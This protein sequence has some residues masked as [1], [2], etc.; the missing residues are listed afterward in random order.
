M[1]G[2]V[3]RERERVL[4]ELQMK[5]KKTR[6]L[7]IGAGL[8]GLSTAYHLEER[9]IKD[10]MLLEKNY[11]IGGLCSSI[12]GNKDYIIDYTGHLLHFQNSY[13]EKLVKKLMPGN[14]NKIKRNSF[15]RAFDRDI[16][17]PFQSNLSY[18]PGNIRNECLIEYLKIH[19]SELERTNI[20]QGEFLGYDNFEDWIN[21]NFGKGIA[22]YFMI[23]YNTKLWTVPPREMST[24]WMNN[25]VPKPEIMHVVR[26]ALLEESKEEGYNAYF[27]YPKTGGIGSL[28]EAFSNKLPLIRSLT[29]VSKIMP[30]EKKVVIENL[31]G[32]REEISYEVLI[33]TMP[34]KEL[35]S[36]RIEETPKEIKDY[37]NKL[38]HNSVYSLV[39]AKKKGIFNKH[40]VYYPESVYN[41][42]R[43]GYFNNFSDSMCPKN[44]ELIYTEYAH[45]GKESQAGMRKK[46]FEDL[47][48]INNSDNFRE[49]FQFDIPCAYVIYDKNREKSVEGIMQYLNS[50]NI[51]SIGRYGAW[52]YS[53]MEDAILGGKEICERIVK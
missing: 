19:T 6:Y 26:G 30:N 39:I 37:G 42:Y 12:G 53:A 22:K 7:I 51:Y 48:Q 45:R 9:G 20:N 16:P 21:R 25:Y 4:V 11:D 3:N 1:E 44:E 5:N 41:T 50:K 27:Y 38:K 23:P 36:D 14:L 28:A 10:Y 15:I 18:L 31:L 40:W 17:Y 24:K 2:F 32:E 47:V 13:V 35:I 34:L 52:E 49:I 8:S 43:M 46:S 29:E 33:N